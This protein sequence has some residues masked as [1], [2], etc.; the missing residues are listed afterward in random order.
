MPKNEQQSNPAAGKRKGIRVL[1]EK[2]L[3]LYYTAVLQHE[4]SSDVGNGNELNHAKR[5]MSG[6]RYGPD[7]FRGEVPNSF[8]RRPQTLAALCFGVGHQTSQAALLHIQRKNLARKSEKSTLNCPNR[9][10][11]DYHL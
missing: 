9:G 8:C 3:S 1:A 11:S 4:S 7:F 2:G 10:K 6:L 5:P